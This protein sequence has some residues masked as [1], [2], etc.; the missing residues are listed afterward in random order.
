MILRWAPSIAAASSVVGGREQGGNVQVLG[1]RECRHGRGSYEIKIC[2][3]LKD[4]SSN[5]AVGICVGLRGGLQLFV[6]SLWDA[7]IVC[8]SSFQSKSSKSK[9]RLR[10]SEEGGGRVREA[11]FTLRVRP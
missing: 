4:A 9:R 5:A 6:V 8:C 11:Q 2:S 1:L 3:Q 10:A 7:G